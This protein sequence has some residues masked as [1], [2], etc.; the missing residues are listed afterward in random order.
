M[1][2]IFSESL[3]KSVWVLCVCACA[4]ACACSLVLGTESGGCGLPERLPPASCPL[5]RKQEI[6][7]ELRTSRLKET[8]FCDWNRETPTPTAGLIGFAICQWP[9]EG[10]WKKCVSITCQIKSFFHIASVRFKQDSCHTAR[11]ASIA[12]AM[13]ATS[14]YLGNY[15]RKLWLISYVDIQINKPWPHNPIFFLVICKSTVP[16][17]G[18]NTSV[19]S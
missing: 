5:G 11:W 16:P 3:N 4:R 6:V 10:I 17:T 18:M 8:K 19:L 9:H 7:L 1:D 2:F 15:Y 13:V 14:A 12:A